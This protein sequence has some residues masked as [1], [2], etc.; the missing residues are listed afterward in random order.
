MAEVVTAIGSEYAFML[1]LES[2][3][4]TL[5]ASVVH[6]VRFGLY[7]VVNNPAEPDLLES[8]GLCDFSG[9][10]DLPWTQGPGGVWDAGEQ[11]AIGPEFTKEWV[12]S[13]GA[14]AND[15]LGWLVYD[16][17]T[18]PVVLWRKAFPAARIMAAS[19]DKVTIDFQLA[20]GH[21]PGP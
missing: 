11:E 9:Y 21:L 2:I 15:V 10:A 5:N 13:G 18:T 4:D 20:I 19:G 3:Q 14:T 7:K 8:Y 1:A 16:D 17:Q 6:E 12:H